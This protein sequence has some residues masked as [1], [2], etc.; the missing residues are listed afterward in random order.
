MAVYW[1]FRRILNVD[2]D[3]NYTCVGTAKTKGRECMHRVGVDYRREGSQVLNEM[4]KTKSYSKALANLED[5]AD[6]L[7]CKQVHNSE[8]NPH[9]NQINEVY[10]KWYAVA[11]E[12]YVLLNKEAERAAERRATRELSLM[13]EAAQQMK[14]ELDRQKDD[15]MIVEVTDMNAGM[16]P[17][18]A[19]PEDDPFVV[20]NVQDIA[21]T[22]PSSSAGPSRATEI[23]WPVVPLHAPSRKIPVFSDKPQE[24]PQQIPCAVNIQ[25]N[26]TTTAPLTIKKNLHYGAPR[27]FGTSMSD[28]NATPDLSFDQTTSTAKSSRLA[29]ASGPGKRVA[30]QDKRAAINKNMASCTGVPSAPDSTFAFGATMPASSFSFEVPKQPQVETVSV[31]E[32]SAVTPSHS[33]ETFKEEVG[34]DSVSSLQTTSIHVDEAS[35]PPPIARSASFGYAVVTPSSTRYKTYLPARQQHG[36]MTPPETPETLLTAH[37]SSSLLPPPKIGDYFSSDSNPNASPKIV[38]KPLPDTPSVDVTEGDI[39]DRE[40][41]TVIAGDAESSDEKSGCLSRFGLGR[42]RGKVMGNLRSMKAKFSKSA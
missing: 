6:L 10:R 3:S 23:N 19:V 30:L 40:P 27:T 18:P 41:R 37:K 20:S 11:K 13:R 4:D 31:A 38:R 22:I 2:P 24:E 39:D 5:L 28:E 26:T 34:L 29:S 1:D 42:L 14:E 35:E 12:E 36:L 33:D 15:M 32:A 16:T 25:A 9:L 17:D 8:K 7:L 21:V